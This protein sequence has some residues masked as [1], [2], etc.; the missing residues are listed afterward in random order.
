MRAGPVCGLAGGGEWIRSFG[1]AMHLHADSV[2]MVWRHLIRAVSGGFLDRRPHLD[3]YAKAGNCSDQRCAGR[4]ASTRTYPRNCC[5]STAE[6]NVRIHSLQQRVGRTLPPFRWER[7][8]PKPF[9]KLARSRRIALTTGGARGS[10]NCSPR[11]PRGGL[12]RPGHPG[13]VRRINRVGLALPSMPRTPAI[14]PSASTCPE[15]IVSSG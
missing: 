13:T 4:S 12:I 5:L 15:K 8:D 6:L 9:A 1:S 11:T 14:S 2:D 10:K 7:R 3:R